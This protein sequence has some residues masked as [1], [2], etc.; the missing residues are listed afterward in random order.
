MFIF[1]RKDLHSFKNTHDTYVFLAG[2]YFSIFWGLQYEE[3]I[4]MTWIGGWWKSLSTESTINQGCPPAA[5]VEGFIVVRAGRLA[6][7]A[8]TRTGFSVDLR[9]GIQHLPEQFLR[10]PKPTNETF[11]SKES[12]IDFCGRLIAQAGGPGNLGGWEVEQ[13][14]GTQ[15]GC[16]L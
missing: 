6:A 16:K 8:L 10:L 1:S 11:L 7:W 2:F 13:C 9:L 3:S 15:A 5:D 4:V 14:Q 12:M